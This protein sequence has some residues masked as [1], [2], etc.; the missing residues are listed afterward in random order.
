MPAKQTKEEF[1]I[2]SI[3]VH[4]DKYDYSNV[5]YN[6]N[7]TE[8][9][10]ICKEH[11]NFTQT[12]QGHLSGRGCKK[13]SGKYKYSTEEWIIMAKEMHGDKYDYSKSIYND[14]NT[15]IN[16]ICKKHGEFQQTPRVHLRPNGCNKCGNVVIATIQTFTQEQFIKQAQNIHG[17]L[18]DYSN[19][20]YINSQSNVQII[21]KVHGMFEQKANGH[22]QGKGC[23]KCSGCDKK[24]TE[25]FIKQSKLVHGDKYD[26]SKCIY[27]S[28]KENVIIICK[29]HGEFKQL[30]HTHLKN[31]GCTKCS[32]KG[33]KTHTLEQFIEYAND[34]H[35]NRYD[36]SKVEYNGSDI[37]ITIICKKHG[38][39]QQKPNG[40]LQGK[41]CIKC[42]GCNLKTTDE[43]IKQATRVHGDKYDYSKT[44]YTI[45]KNK[46]II[47]CKK[48]G[49]FEQNPNLHL[50]DC[51]CNK[52]C[53]SKKYS[54][55]QIKWLN[56]IQIKD[57][58]FIE[59]AE[60]SKEFIVP[61]TRYRADGWCRET[62]TI[63][64]YHGSYWHGDPKWFNAIAL[65]KVTHC[66]FGELYEKTMQ[67][68]K[69]IKEL[70]YNLVVMWESD[71]NKINKSI[72]SLQRKFRS[73]HL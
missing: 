63:Y 49:D 28:S 4:G 19:V 2:K 60:N 59:H 6:N 58:I 53:N 9:N 71:W 51:G 68:E 52:C 12:P 33:G 21:C 10:I 14:A 32:G 17:I 16:I 40:H 72:R 65:N 25:E 62:N 41:G 7:H 1:I 38:E 22:L 3:R 37:F 23:I 35:G 64:E 31:C 30:P 54:K 73:N 39:F 66:T 29:K 46:I 44:I 67:K 24:T 57:N 15:K 69:T 18:Y 26:Y 55:E 11:G 13:C 61:T 56:F 36:Y 48:C 43:F 50:K 8:I 34:K 5:E 47:T 42:G 70:G 45:A 20:K 27:N